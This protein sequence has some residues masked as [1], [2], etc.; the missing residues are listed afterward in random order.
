MT[1]EPEDPSLPYP[2]ITPYLYYADAAA[3]IEW[4]TNAFGFVERRRLEAPDGTVAHA[5]LAAGAD[6]VIMFGSPGEEYD[7]RGSGR[8][9][10]SSLYVRVDDPDGHAGRARSPERASSS[11]RWTGR[12]A[13][14]STQRRIS[15]AI[16]GSSGLAGPGGRGLTCREVRRPRGRRPERSSTPPD[17]TTPGRGKNEAPGVAVG[18]LRRGM[19]IVV[20]RLVDISEVVGLACV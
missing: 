11:T 5:E 19:R 9:V 2:T 13:T 16:G 20:N 8:R 6:G 4:L 14:A 1:S 15:R 17:S 10:S 7:S 18:G 3:A 12:G